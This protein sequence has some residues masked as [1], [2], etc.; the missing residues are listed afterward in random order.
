MKPEYLVL[1]A[2]SSIVY[3][4]GNTYRLNRSD[5]CFNDSKQTVTL[6]YTNEQISKLTYDLKNFSEQY[7]VR[8]MITGIKSLCGAISSLHFLVMQRGDNN[9]LQYA[10][11]ILHEPNFFRNEQYRNF[12]FGSENCPNDPIGWSDDK[13]QI[14]PVLELVLSIFFVLLLILLI[15]KY[16]KY[17]NRAC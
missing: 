8:L 16:C 10:H 12:F 15:T 13:K 1:I 5:V 9:E 2:L 11:R 14:I 3:K 7:F 4:Y 17:N 6:P